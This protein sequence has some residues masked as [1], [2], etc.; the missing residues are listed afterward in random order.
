VWAADSFA[1][2][3]LPNVEAYSADAGDK[4]HTYDFLGVSEQQV[5]ENFRRYNLFDRQVQFLKGW[6]KDTLPE[7]PIDRLAILRLDGDMYESTIQALESLYHKLSPGGFVIID[8]YFLGPCRQAVTD[9][10][11]ANRIND[12]IIDIDGWGVFWRRA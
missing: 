1:G 2:L 8:D 9:F 10:R 4:H 11:N 7:A 5:E 12:P 6:F 3:P